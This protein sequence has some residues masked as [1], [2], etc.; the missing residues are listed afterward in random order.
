MATGANGGPNGPGVGGLNPGPGGQPP[1]GIQ[2]AGAPPGG[3]GAP[4]GGDGGA[5]GIFLQNLLNR[6]TQLEQQ[7]QNNA[8]Q[9]T[10]VSN[11]YQGNINPTTSNGLKMY[12]SATTARE[13]LLTPKIKTKKEF[14]DAMASDSARFGWGSL[15]NQVVVGGESFSILKDVQKLDVDKVRQH[16]SKFLYQDNSTDVPPENH[17]MTL[18]AINPEN[19]NNHKNI[20]YA[21]V[22]I[23]MIGQRIW[24]SL[25][26]QS[27]FSEI[28]AVSTANISDLT[29]AEQVLTSALSVFISSEH[30]V[31]DNDL[32]SK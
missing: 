21:R 8:S 26:Q 18:F 5:G 15:I 24:N 28:F 2:P 13:T 10:F 30:A 20:F 25:S 1:P 32:E 22:K 14:L 3:D 17:F 4:P 12:Q 29:V 16:T 11:P 9:E 31:K 7:N 27:D 23:N 6:I 19:D